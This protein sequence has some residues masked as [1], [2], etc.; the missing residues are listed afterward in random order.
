M[1]ALVANSERRGGA[2]SDSLGIKDGIFSCEIVK[3]GCVRVPMK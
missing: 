2:V 3:S 1:V